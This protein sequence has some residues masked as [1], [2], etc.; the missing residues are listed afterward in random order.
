MATAR[1]L[2]LGVGR[3]APPQCQASL[4][5]TAKEDCNV[6]SKVLSNN[7]D[8]RL[9]WLSQ[10]MSKLGS[11][12]AMVTI[13]LLVL[14]R[15]SAADAGL[16]AFVV[17]ATAVATTLP[18]GALSDRYRGRTIL[19][20]CEL[21]CALAIAALALAVTMTAS[22]SLPLILGVGVIDGALGG[23]FLSTSA[24]ALPRIVTPRELPVA[25]GLVQARNAAVYLVGPVLGGLL[26][27][28][29]RALPFAVD[30]ASY[31]LSA[32][33]IAC[34][35]SDLGV[36]ETRTGGLWRDLAAGLAL[37]WDHGLLRYAILVAAA[38]NFAFGGLL[39][40]V[41][42]NLRASGA[43]PVAIGIVSAAAGLGALI[44]SLLAPRLAEKLTLRQAM[45]GLLFVLAGLIP[46]LAA[47]VNV[48]G[49][50]AI[51]AASSLLAPAL[52][53]LIVS[54]QIAE[55]PDEFQGRVQG[56][57]AFA[58]NGIGPLGPLVG[59][60]LL[61]LIGGPET[62]LLTG[63]F[64]GLLGVASLLTPALA[65]VRRATA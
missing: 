16:I 11:A 52:N 25:V 2:T 43:A 32:S 1:N 48:V 45:A 50:T 61:T 40:V 64:F 13:P 24:A 41:V 65:Q 31:F 54:A 4:G 51:I 55:T 6:H 39:L 26:F 28:I 30:A 38:L 29:D 59:G 63:L 10:A 57:V 5:P 14:T 46:I 12:T 8:F 36:M 3:S 27:E 60:L 22:A 62:F 9:L 17:A 34:L 33:L 23:V 37:V 49:V 47:S 35:Q 20:G 58:A 19:V 56:A 44:G 53:V 42:A 7:R 15:Y 21:C 18:G